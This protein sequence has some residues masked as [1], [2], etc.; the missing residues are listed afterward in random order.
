MHI[1]YIL[2]AIRFGFVVSFS[3][4][5][6]LNNRSA[7]MVFQFNYIGQRK[8]WITICTP[9]ITDVYWCIFTLVEPRVVVTLH[10][11]YSRSSS[12]ARWSYLPEGW[13]TKPSSFSRLWSL[14]QGP[15]LWLIKDLLCI[16]NYLRTRARNSLTWFCKI[17]QTPFTE[18]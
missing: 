4:T 18:S 6:A 17:H 16:V 14:G 1:N 5:H 15:I 13:S 8:R 7:A 10:E 12:I 11:T 9:L 2:R 3:S